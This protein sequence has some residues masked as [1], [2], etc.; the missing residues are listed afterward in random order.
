V[1][2][3]PTRDFVDPGMPAMILVSAAGQAWFGHGLLAESIVV[4]TAFGLASALTVIAA[5]QLSGSL[6]VGIVAAILEALSFPRSY[7]YPK[8]L[9]YAAA[10][11]IL[12]SYLRRP[13]AMRATAV[14]GCVAVAFLF[15]HDHGAYIAAGALIAAA[16]AGAGTSRRRAARR[17]M[18]MGG[19]IAAAMAP[20]LAYVQATEGVIPYFER[21]IIFSRAEY[22]RNA[23]ALPALDVAGG[24]AGNAAPLLFYLFHALPAVAVVIAFHRYRPTG[25]TDSWRILPF[26]GIAALANIGFMRDPL[27]DRVA[28][29]IAP[30]VLVASWIAGTLLMKR[31]EPE[32]TPV[33]PIA[34]KPLARAFAWAAVSAVTL[35]SIVA[36]LAIGNGLGRVRASGVLDV[37]RAPDLLHLVLDQVGIY[38]QL[39]SPWSLPSRTAAALVSFFAYVGRCT[40][41]SDRLL[42]PGFVPEVAFL[43][44]RPFAGGQSELRPRYYGPPDETRVLARLASQRTIFV[45][46]ALDWRDATNF[47]FPRLASYIAS[48]FRPLLE[49]RFDDRGNGVR[50]DVTSTLA[51]TGIDALTGWPCFR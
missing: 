47:A 30:A 12:W 29:A 1:Q 48:S 21:A 19:I 44:D 16:V 11:P 35:V 18:V 6:A 5:T 39:Y 10:A 26:I 37:R 3:R 7:S 32:G 17:V 24:I 43:A 9:V 36:L 49:V 22:T 13:T 45:V 20:Y 51:A 41:A 38:R 28:D 4:A 14:S 46:Q 33:E 23:F 50:V 40:S 15:R 25:S 27:A 31:P 42:L 34:S 2:P 8:V